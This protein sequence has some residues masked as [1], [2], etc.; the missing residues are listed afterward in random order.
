M[1]AG[2]VGFGWVIDGPYGWV[3]LSGRALFGQLSVGF[4]LALGRSGFK[5]RSPLLKVEGKPRGC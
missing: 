4:S 1:R 5:M 2:L 3:G